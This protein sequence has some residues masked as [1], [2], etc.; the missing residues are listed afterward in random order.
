MISKVKAKF[1]NFGGVMIY[2]MKLMKIYLKEIKI[3]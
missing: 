2:F 3:N 1:Y